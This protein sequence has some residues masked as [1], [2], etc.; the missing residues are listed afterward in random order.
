RGRGRPGEESRARRGLRSGDALEQG[1]WETLRRAVRWKEGSRASQA[2]ECEGF[3]FS[4]LLLLLCCFR[5]GSS[6]GST[7][8]RRTILWVGRGLATGVGVLSRRQLCD[9]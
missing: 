8:S 5:L 6:C 4:R 2:C 1:T 7:A 3:G 9:G